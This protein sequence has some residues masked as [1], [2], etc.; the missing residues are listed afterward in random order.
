METVSVA[1]VGTKTMSS[2]ML[3]KP[4]RSRT[5]LQLGDI[6]LWPITH[7]ST[8]L[9]MSLF[10]ALNI[11]IVVLWKSSQLLK[12]AGEKKEKPKKNKEPIPDCIH[13]VSL[14]FSSGRLC[15]L[16]FITRLFLFFGVIL[17]L[18]VCIYVYMFSICFFCSTSG[19]A[20]HCTPDVWRFEYKPFF[21]FYIFVQLSRWH[22]TV[23]TWHGS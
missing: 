14:L 3:K 6:C 12:P 21:F 5:D 4:P 16:V 15:V 19:F 13:G 1:A 10:L 23:N 11:C 2:I 8:L 22:P 9:Q 18:S 17:C 20:F 7:A